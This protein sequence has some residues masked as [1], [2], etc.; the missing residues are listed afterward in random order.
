M[1]NQIKSILSGII[2]NCK[3]KQV[4]MYGEKR[5]LSTGLVKSADFCVIIPDESIN[6]N[7]VLR[8]LYLTLDVE[9][10][11][12]VLLY[13]TEEWRTLTEDFSSYA[14]AICKKG[15]VLYEQES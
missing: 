5:S 13:T 9:I 11:F 1:D 14:S 2:S 4:V 10:P 8:T 15:T 3:P 7:T 6:K 12:Q